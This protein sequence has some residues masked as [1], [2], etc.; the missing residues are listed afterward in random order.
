ML[1]EHAPFKKLNK[2]ELKPKTKPWIRKEILF[3][4]WKRE[5]LLSKY[6]R[7][8]DNETAYYNL[9]KQ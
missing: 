3:L 1:D 2:N 9:T 6:H 5:K 8:K 4:M 7:T